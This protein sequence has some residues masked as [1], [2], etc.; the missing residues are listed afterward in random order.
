MELQ[1][2]FPKMLISDLLVD[3]E[4]PRIIVACSCGEWQYEADSTTDCCFKI[5]HHASEIWM[6][7]HMVPLIARL[8]V[9]EKWDHDHLI[10]KAMNELEREI[11]EL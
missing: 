9:T 6:V 11:D 7:D 1:E 10:E 5:L 4:N 2:H 8:H 3:T